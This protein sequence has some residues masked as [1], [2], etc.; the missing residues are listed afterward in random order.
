[1]SKQVEGIYGRE[2]FEKYAALAQTPLGL[3]IYTARWALITR[4]CQSPN[5][6]NHYSTILD[7][8][9]GPGSF[10]AHGPDNFRKFNFDI[11]PSCGFTDLPQE[12]MDILT[13]WDSIEH[14]PNFYG[15]IK[16]IDAE[17]LFITTPNLES[18]DKPVTF[19]K[20]YR[21]KEHIYYFDR[22]S[23]EVILEDLGYKIIELNFDEGRLRD[24]QHPNAVL[25]LVAKKCN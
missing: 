22:H 19:W 21:P 12:K 4:F 15:L 5:I 2:Y 20:H 9:S 7:Y 11:N 24:P 14:I 25:T 18:V 3:A 10:N 17:W 6:D 13:L 8:G 23:L 1:M 16:S